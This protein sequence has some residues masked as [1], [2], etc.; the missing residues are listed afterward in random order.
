MT[1]ESLNGRRSPRQPHCGVVFLGSERHYFKKVSRGGRPARADVGSAS[2]VCLT[3]KTAVYRRQTCTSTDIGA[4]GRIQSAR[5]ASGRLCTGRTL[6]GGSLSWR[7]CVEGRWSRSLARRS[8]G[9]IVIMAS[10][11]RSDHRQLMQAG[12]QGPWARRHPAVSSG[13]YRGEAFYFTRTR[14]PLIAVCGAIVRPAQMSGWQSRSRSR[15]IGHVRAEEQRR[16]SRACPQGW[17]G[18]SRMNFLLLLDP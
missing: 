11:R 7:A 10:Y 18:L 15:R 6:Q 2:R 13:R 4:A 9:D 1:R 12:M 8:C 5:R 14:S 17:N 3:H 16:R